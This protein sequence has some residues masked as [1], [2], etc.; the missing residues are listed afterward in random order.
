MEVGCRVEIEHRGPGRALDTTKAYLTFVGIDKA[1]AR[2]RSRR[3][4][5]R[6][7]RTGAAARGEGAATSAAAGRGQGDST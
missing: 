1:D 2:A 3:S 4:S 6:A 5:S 7:T